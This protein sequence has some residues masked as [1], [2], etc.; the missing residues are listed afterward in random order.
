MHKDME[1]SIFIIIRGYI[2]PTENNTSLAIVCQEI[3]FFAN[4]HLPCLAKNGIRYLYQIPPPEL[5]EYP[6]DGSIY[7]LLRPVKN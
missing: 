7:G 1:W 3:D 4:I 2:A 5:Q 6:D